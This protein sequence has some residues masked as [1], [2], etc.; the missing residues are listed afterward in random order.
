[1]CS[2]DTTEMNETDESVYVDRGYRNRTA[3]LRELAEESSCDLETVAVVADTLGPGE[4]FDGL[5][6]ILGD[7]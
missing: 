1:M 7:L 6:A 2:E 5:R 4:D 3:Y